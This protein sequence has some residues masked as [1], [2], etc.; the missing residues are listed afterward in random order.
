MRHGMATRKFNRTKNQRK[1]LLAGLANDLIHKERLFTT[2]PKAKDLRPFVEKLITTSKRSP[3]LSAYRLMYSR[4]RLHTACNKLV[5][6]LA[7][8]YKERPGGYVRIMKAGYRYG[9]N[10]PMAFIEF[11]DGSF[12]SQ[13]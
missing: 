7:P 6:V 11:V 12:A 13:A 1:A 4:L 2:L 9:D 3:S 8:R 10:A 5:N